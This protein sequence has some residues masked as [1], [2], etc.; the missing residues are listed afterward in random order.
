MLMAMTPTRSEIERNALAEAAREEERAIW[1]RM[2]PSV[3]RRNWYILKVLRQFENAVSGQLLGL[4]VA[5][6]YSPQKYADRIVHQREMLTGRRIVVGRQRVLEPMFPGYLFVRFDY[7][8]EWPKIR[9]RV[10]VERARTCDRPDG[11]PYVVHNILMQAIFEAEMESVGEDKRKISVFEV[12]Q[13]VRLLTGPFAEFIGNIERLD[14]GDRIRVLLDLF[15]RQTP[16][17]KP[18]H[19][20]EAVE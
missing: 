5:N 3:D 20:I 11:S 10:P 18:A 7:Q 4:K 6:V 17:V 9:A 19:E 12:G 2:R 14:S 15:G 1:R 13:A 8:A 16:V